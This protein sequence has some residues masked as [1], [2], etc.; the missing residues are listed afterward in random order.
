MAGTQESQGLLGVGLVGPERPWAA[1]VGVALAPRSGK[2]ALTTAAGGLNELQATHG[3]PARSRRGREATRVLGMIRSE[4]EYTA[5]GELFEDI[6][7]VMER[8]QSAC[9][10]ASDAVAQRYFPRGVVT[11]WQ[12]S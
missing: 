3:T 7:Q 8:V 1:G 10:V 2:R 11:S 12:A 4:L 5:T 6:Y 9:S